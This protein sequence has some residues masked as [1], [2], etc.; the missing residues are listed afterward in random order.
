MVNPPIP[1]PTKV[2]LQLVLGSFVPAGGHRPTLH[3]ERGRDAPSSNTEG[4]SRKLVAATSFGDLWGLAAIR[5]DS[6]DAPASAPQAPEE[7][8]ASILEEGPPSAPEAQEGPPSVQ[9]EGAPC[10]QEEG[11]PSVEKEGAP[12]VEGEGAP[13]IEE[14]GPPSV[15]EEGAPS[16]EEER[17]PSVEEEGAP[18]V[19]APSAAEE[20]APSFLAPEVASSTAAAPRAC[21]LL[22]IKVKLRS[23]PLWT[24]VR[25]HTTRAI[26]W[27]SVRHWEELLLLEPD[28]LQVRYTIY[29]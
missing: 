29:R 2:R 26:R 9:E 17:G 13:S 20:G 1:H 23:G 10:A 25:E 19:E 8:G 28:T 6:G 24:V 22:K 12:S 27:P 18:S 4:S 3:A 16:V 5:S 15:E 11:A 14:E 7:G 21:T